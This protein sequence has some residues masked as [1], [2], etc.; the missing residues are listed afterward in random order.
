MIGRAVSIKVSV[1]CA[2]YNRPQYIKDT[3]KGLL[4]Q[5]LE[6]YEVI[7]VNDGSPDASVE[8]IL[9]TYS[10]TRL[11]V[12]HQKNGGFVSAIKKAISQS[13]GEYIAI[14]GAGDVSDTRRL[15][16][17]SQYLDHNDD[18]VAVG[19]WVKKTFVSSFGDETDDGAIRLNKGKMDRA[20]F[21]KRSNPFTHGEV[22]FRAS[23]YHQAGGYRDLF[24]HAQDR[25][26]WLRMSFH[27]KFS[28]IPQ[29]LYIRRSFEA[30]GVSADIRKLI[31]QKKLSAFA[32]QCAKM[33]ERVGH[34]HVDKH[35]HHAMFYYER[36]SDVSSYV[37]RSILKCIAKQRLD[38]ARR[39]KQELHYER[40]SLESVLAQVA[41]PL[42]ANSN[43]ALTLV[44]K[45]ISLKKFSD[46]N[47]KKADSGPEA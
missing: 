6:N 9:S 20:D 26:L 14:Q 22:M 17:Q 7:L 30:D 35:G 25:D 15:E 13:K 24:K 3:L 16:L 1:V 2:W 10:D 29:E 32:R 39:L 42:C 31:L 18:V 45:L 4:S 40:H 44:S 47:I 12:I 27:G 37:G 38:D 23:I 19:S 43:V 46:T 28:I 34:D 33:R 41:L 11:T 8:Q 21:M 36:N 5:T